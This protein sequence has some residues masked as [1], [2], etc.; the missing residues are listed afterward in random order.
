MGVQ[1]DHFAYPGC[2]CQ[3]ANGTSDQAPPSPGPDVVN[4]FWRA[5][6]KRTTSRASSDCCLEYVC[7]CTLLSSGSAGR[8]PHSRVLKYLRHCTVLWA[9]REILPLC[10]MAMFPL[11][12]DPCRG[13]TLCTFFARFVFLYCVFSLLLFIPF[14]FVLRGR[15]TVALNIDIGRPSQIV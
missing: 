10:F 14:P 2:V 6:K 11:S 8:I 7:M 12:P 15:L 5:V 3:P 9:K 13:R 1:S 4:N